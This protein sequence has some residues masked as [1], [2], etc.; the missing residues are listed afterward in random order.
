MDYTI[1]NTVNYAAF[2]YGSYDIII[3]RIKTD[4]S[5]NLSFSYGPGINASIGALNG[6]Q[7]LENSTLTAVP[8][9]S[10]IVLIGVGSFFAIMEKKS[11]RYKKSSR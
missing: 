3:R 8:E 2:V 9:P 10:T 5:G 11:K 4:T 6:I 1:T 7:L